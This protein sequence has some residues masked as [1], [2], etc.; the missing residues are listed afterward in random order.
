MAASLRPTF[1]LSPWVANHCP[2]FCQDS[3]S[4][5]LGSSGKNVAIRVFGSAC[6]IFCASAWNSLQVAGG[7]VIP[8]L[9]NRSL[10]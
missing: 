10:R 8:A 6:L 2:P 9:A 5:L 4:R 3:A 7:V 1:Q